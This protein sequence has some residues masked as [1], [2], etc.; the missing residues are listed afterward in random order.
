MR[1][2]RNLGGN[3]INKWEGEKIGRGEGKRKR[4]DFSIAVLSEINTHNVIEH[5][6]LLPPSPLICVLPP[7]SFSWRESLL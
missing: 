5:T 4:G 6:F 3:G 7:C 2:S 1:N